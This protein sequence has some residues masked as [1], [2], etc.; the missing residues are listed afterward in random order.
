MSQA[1]GLD[2]RG[3]LRL[4]EPAQIR[5]DHAE[6]RSGERRHLV[7]PHIRRVRKPVEEDDGGASP[8]TST[9]SSTP[10]PCTRRIAV[11]LGRKNH[12]GAAG[13]PREPGIGRTGSSSASDERRRPRRAARATGRPRTRYGGVGGR[14]HEGHARPRLL[15]RRDPDG[16]PALGGA[17][18]LPRRGRRTLV[19]CELRL[20][21]LRA[22]RG[23]GRGRRPDRVL[24]PR[25]R[26]GDVDRRRGRRLDDE[27]L[28]FHCLVP[29]ATWWDDI[30]FT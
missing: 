23:A 10:S 2:V 28:V 25:L 13:R 11:E 29:A 1:I 3:F 14:L 6:A 18:A 5:R 15:G 12:P 21:R 17:H 24:V 7:P 22:L 4:A 30:V 9:A 20:G 16:E 26:R 8:S 19:V 27:M